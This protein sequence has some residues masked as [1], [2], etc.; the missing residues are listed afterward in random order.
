[1]VAVNEWEASGRD[2]GYL[3]PGTGSTTTAVGATTGLRLTAAEHD[4][5]AAAVI[6]A[7]EAAPS[8]PARETSDRRLRRRSRTATDRTV[9]A[10]AV[11]DRRD[12]VP[13]RL[14]TETNVAPS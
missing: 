12:R 3:L 4:F 9:R 11:F 14:T 6:A 10:A 5:I 13:D 1:M 7:R 2:D 8:K